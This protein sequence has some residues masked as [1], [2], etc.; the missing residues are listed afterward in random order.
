[1][2]AKDPA[3]LERFRASQRAS[4]AEDREGATVF[5]ARNAWDLNRTAETWPAIRFSAT[6]ERS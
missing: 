4:L 3:E 5:L 1:V 2:S 6:R